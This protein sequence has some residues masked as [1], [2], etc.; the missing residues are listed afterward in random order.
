MDQ[1]DDLTDP[2]RMPI[3][4]DFWIGDLEVGFRLP[5]RWGSVSLRLLNFTDKEFDFYLSSLEEDIVPARTALLSV[6]FTSR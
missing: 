4:S 6:N 1:F 2:L 5:K 3:K